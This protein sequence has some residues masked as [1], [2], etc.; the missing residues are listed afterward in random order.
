MSDE[1]PSSLNVRVFMM[2]KE[3]LWYEFEHGFSQEGSS[4]KGNPWADMLSARALSQAGAGPS[5]RDTDEVDSD[6]IEAIYSEE[7]PNI[8]ETEMLEVEFDVGSHPGEGMLLKNP[9]SSVKT[10]DIKLWRYLYRKPSSV[11]IRVPTEHERVDWVV[12]GWVAVY[13][14]MLKDGMRFPI[15]RLI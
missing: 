14:L 12:P 7:T 1:E 9:R 15:P 3:A 6:D 10:E 4:S 5:G 2:K 8:A 11:E 13:E